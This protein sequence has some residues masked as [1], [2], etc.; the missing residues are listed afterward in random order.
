M[1]TEGA[2]Q[3][4]LFVE[5]IVD[6]LLLEEGLQALSSHECWGAALATDDA[7]LGWRAEGD[8]TPGFVRGREHLK[9]K[10]CD[11]CRRGG[12]FVRVDRVRVQTHH[13]A[14]TKT[15]GLWHRLPSD[16][17]VGYRVIN[18]T[19]KCKGPTLLVF[20]CEPPEEVARLAPPND[21]AVIDGRWVHLRLG[22][23]TLM[24]S[25][26]RS[27]GAPAP[28][29]QG[30]VETSDDRGTKRARDAASVSTASVCARR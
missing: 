15:P 9:N 25:E 1:M 28:P 13:F 26:D 5:D 14:N 27:V 3:G 19:S 2:D 30:G 12:I 4:S 24:P 22:Y 17:D 6:E 23:G 11:N 20:S 21:A 18:Q 16:P 7:K 29:P 10:F 8:C